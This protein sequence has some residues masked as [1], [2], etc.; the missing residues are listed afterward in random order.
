MSRCC[1]ACVQSA[2]RRQEQFDGGYLHQSRDYPS[3]LHCNVCGAY[4]RPDLLASVVGQEQ[5]K[6]REVRS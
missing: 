1:P 4:Y 2:Q 6:F 3:L 5:W